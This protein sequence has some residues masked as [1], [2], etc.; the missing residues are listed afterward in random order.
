MSEKISTR[1]YRVILNKNSKIESVMVAAKLS[2]NSPLRIGHF[3]YRNNKL[4]R[5]DN[6][7]DCLRALHLAM[8]KCVRATFKQYKTKSS[9]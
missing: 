9:Q 7:K 3:A 2:D 6:H 8:L 4:K 5:L 1:V